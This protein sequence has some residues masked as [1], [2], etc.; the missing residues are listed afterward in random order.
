MTLRVVPVG[1]RRARQIV[2]AMHAQH[3][4][5]EAWC[6]PCAS[7][8][9]RIVVCHICGR[10]DWRTRAWGYTPLRG[11]ARSRVATFGPGVN[12]RLR[13]MLRGEGAAL[14]VASGGHL[15]SRRPQRYCARLKTRCATRGTEHTAGLAE[16]A[17]ITVRREVWR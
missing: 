15:A 16:R 6:E 5:A 1:V 12:A 17:G 13:R 14:C 8:C 2:E 10:M 11:N 7:M 3:P 4:G 9:E